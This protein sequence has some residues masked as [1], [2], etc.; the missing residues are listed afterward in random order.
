M[1]VLMDVS[2]GNSGVEIGN[3]IAVYL[4]AAEKTFT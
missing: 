1:G 3:E 4:P 2:S